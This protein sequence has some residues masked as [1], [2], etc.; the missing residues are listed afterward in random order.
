MGSVDF[1]NKVKEK[2]FPEKIDDEVPQSRELA[3]DPYQIQKI[4]CEYYGIDREKLFYPEEAF[5]M[6]RETLLSIWP[7]DLEAIV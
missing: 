3:P 7:G 4:V 6:S 1:I 5:L 2:F